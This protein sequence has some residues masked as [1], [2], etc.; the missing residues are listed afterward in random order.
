MS[1]ATFTQCAFVVIDFI[2]STQKSLQQAPVSRQSALT[3]APLWH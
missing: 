3:G 1:P 2:R